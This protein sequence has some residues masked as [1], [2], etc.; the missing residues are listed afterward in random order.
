MDFE[1]ILMRDTGLTLDDLPDRDEGYWDAY[2]LEDGTLDY[3]GI[4]KD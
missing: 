4:D 2:I 1:T 3:D